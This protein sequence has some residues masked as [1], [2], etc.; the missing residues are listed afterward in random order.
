MK[1]LKLLVPL[2]GAT[3]YEWQ[4]GRVYIRVCYL[5]GRY[6]AWKPWRRVRVIL[7]KAEQ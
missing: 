2:K 3:A 6:W 7:L 4:F 1:V 5:D